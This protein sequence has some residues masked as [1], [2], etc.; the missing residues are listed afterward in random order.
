MAIRNSPH[1]AK[2]KLTEGESSTACATDEAEEK[3]HELA[4]SAVQKVQDV[5]HKAQEWAANVANKAQDTASAAVDKANEGITAV[6]H[7]MSALG[8][9]V[10][11]T[12]PHHG[13]IGSAATT[14]A[15]QL[16]AGGTYLE[17]HG[18]KDMGKDLTSLVRQYPIQ[19]VLVGIG[20]GYLLARTW[21]RS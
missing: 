13:A 21:K 10:R 11:E 18:L 17:G 7:Q 6:G 15:D 20:I 14:M 8:N 4:S 3:A 12:A 2:K 9:T 19:S 16:Q 5:A 1:D